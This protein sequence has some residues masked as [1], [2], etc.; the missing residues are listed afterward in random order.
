[1]YVDAAVCAGCHG[2]IA[3]TYRRTGMGR[4]FHPPT[5]ETT[6]GDA[7]KPV[8]FYHKA[9]DSYFT[10]E[11]RDGRI[12][13]G[14]Y[15][16]GFDGKKTNILEKEVDFVLGSGNHA[17]TFLSRSSPNQAGRNT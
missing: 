14:R 17:R 5:L 3:E 6:V 15:Q 9:S 11:Q 8:T 1:A 16:L 2:K 4:S 7:T 10:M 13:Q 12:F